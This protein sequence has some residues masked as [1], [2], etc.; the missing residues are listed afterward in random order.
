MPLP[1]DVLLEYAITT[2][3]LDYGCQI[4]E[5][6]SLLQHNTKQHAIEKAGGMRCAV[7]WANLGVSLHLCFSPKRQS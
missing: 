1:L 7:C 2:A 3:G 5:V 6:T 4:T